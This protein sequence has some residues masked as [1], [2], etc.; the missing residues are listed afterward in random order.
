MKVSGCKG[1]KHLLK[2]KREETEQASPQ[3]EVL[4]NTMRAEPPLE[5]SWGCISLSED[6]RG[7]KRKEG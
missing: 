2:N 7:V 5:G 4:Q 3:K 6:M 1:P